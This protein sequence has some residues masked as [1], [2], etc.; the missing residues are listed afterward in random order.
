MNKNNYNKSIDRNYNTNTSVLF[1][2]KETEN[3][4]DKAL[5]L[6]KGLDIGERSDFTERLEN[7]YNIQFDSTHVDLDVEPLD[8]K[9]DIITSFEVLEH[10]FNPLF[11]LLEIKK[12]MSNNAVLYISTPLYKPRII[13]SPNHF[14]EMSEDEL[15]NLIKRANLKIKKKK[16][17]KVRPSLHY[18]SGVR[19]LLR[20]MYERVILLKLSKD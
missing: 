16:I 2:W 14:H 7:I 11:N 20:A 12:V 15:M 1:R 13:K 19:P 8:G 18:L 10:L 17:I 3:F 6:K 4:I 9:Y 5:K